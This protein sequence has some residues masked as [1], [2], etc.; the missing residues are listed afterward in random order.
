[1]LAG[2]FTYKAGVMGR[3]S[4]AL[5]RQLRGK[6]DLELVPPARQ[7]KLQVDNLQPS[8]A[9]DGTQNAAVASQ[10]QAAMSRVEAAMEQRM[11]GL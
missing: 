11:R 6:G 2:F 8:P 5:F 1:V 7:P 10:T 4:L 9:G 3:S